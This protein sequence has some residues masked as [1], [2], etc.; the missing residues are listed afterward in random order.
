MPFQHDD[1]FGA[2]ANFGAL[3]AAFRK[4]V[5]GKRRKPGAV[6]LEGNLSR[7]ERELLDRS[8]RDGVCCRDRSIH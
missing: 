1:L 2:I 4:A 8:W 3:H 6:G 7:L 5:L